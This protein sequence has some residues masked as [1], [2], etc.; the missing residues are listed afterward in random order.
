MSVRARNIGSA[1]NNEYFASALTDTDGYFA[2]HHVRAGRVVVRALRRDRSPTSAGV[3]VVPRQHSTVTLRSTKAP[4]ACC[5]LAGS[6]NLT[7]V[8]ERSDYNWSL[9]RQALGTIR[10]GDSP[11]SIESRENLRRAHAKD[12]PTLDEFGVSAFDLRPFGRR[13]TESIIAHAEAPDARLAVYGYVHEGDQVFI[14][15][16]SAE[17]VT[18]LGGLTLEGRIE[19]EVIRGHWERVPSQ[20][21]R[22][23]D[24]GSFVMTRVAPP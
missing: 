23:T 7:L 15:M 9:P 19:G 16:D 18:D 14:E 2:I 24:E 8:L 6:W 3:T 5:R 11:P 12:D 1:F 17:E 21:R 20:W 10:F 22:G 13:F 4:L